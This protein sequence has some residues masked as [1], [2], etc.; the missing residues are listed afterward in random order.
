MD[1]LEWKESYS[2]G[3]DALDAD[4]KRLIDLINRL[5]DPDGSGTTVPQALSEL[6]NYVRYH[7]RA[8]EERLEAVDY[9]DLTAHKDQHARFEEWLRS[10]QHSYTMAPETR[11][12][13][14]ER[15]NNHLRDWL[16][17]H[18]LKTDMDYKDWL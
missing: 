13:L 8:E 4:H 5:S 10:V 11:A 3:V 9:P 7:F 14:G 1:L 17:N 6:D 18:I 2:V 15:V 12:I 16:I